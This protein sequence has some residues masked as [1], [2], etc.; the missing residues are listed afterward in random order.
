[1]GS[2][3]FLDYEL[4]LLL[5]KHGKP[6]VLRALAGKLDLG[7]DELERILETALNGGSV[8]LTKRKP[9]PADPIEELAAAYPDKAKLLWTLHTYF[10]NRKFL[11]ELRDVKRFFDQ[12]DYPLGATRSRS[13]SLPKQFKLLAELDVSELETLCQTHPDGEYSSLGVIAD[14][15]LRQ[16]KGH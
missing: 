10:E 2:S 7:P 16:D 9:R 8:A 11:P 4:T 14:E 15:I 6:A 5:A 1:M 13:E 3:K 12:H